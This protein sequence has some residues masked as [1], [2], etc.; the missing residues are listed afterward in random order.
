MPGA[1]GR[2]NTRNASPTVDLPFAVNLCVP[3][4]Y[5]RGI[6]ASEPGE[7]R[8]ARQREV[9]WN[10]PLQSRDRIRCRP[11][12]QCVKSVQRGKILKLHRGILREAFLQ[13]GSEPSRF[14]NVA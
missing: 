14:R 12:T 2:V 7:E 8:R 10:C 5:I 6:S 11:M 3:D 4:A 9:V 1:A 13:V